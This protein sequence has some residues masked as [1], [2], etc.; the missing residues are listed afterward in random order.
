MKPV[1]FEHANL[2]YLPSGYRWG[3]LFRRVYLGA[4]YPPFLDRVLEAR[5]KAAERGAQ[6]VSEH[7]FRS[8]ALQHQL[9]GL[10]LAG[11]GGRAAPAGLS[12]HQYGLADDCTAD[13]DPVKPGLQP[14]WEPKRYAILGEES[15]RVGL[16]WG[17]S[18]N[19]RPHT[20]WPGFVSASE[21]KVLQKIWREA[22]DATDD[23]KLR[24]IW[25][26]LSALPAPPSTL[27]PSKK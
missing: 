11:K 27:V 23:M 19:D 17:A 20:Q 5:A 10:F 12:A 25:Q 24:A 1:T 13:A 18:F 7:G 6:Y 3:H 26:Y 2:E 4:Y 9:R 22:S 8:W 21:L 16:I 14:T 15:Q